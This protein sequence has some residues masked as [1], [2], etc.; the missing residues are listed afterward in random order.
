MAV[1]DPALRVR[2]GALCVARY[3]TAPTGKRRSADPAAPRRYRQDDA[4]GS[5][6]GCNMITRGT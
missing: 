4:S 6:S 3:Y 2:G 1:V 5:R